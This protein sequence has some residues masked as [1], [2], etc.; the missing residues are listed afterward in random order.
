MYLV[1]GLQYV[2]GTWVAICIHLV[3]YLGCNMYLVL[4]LQC[5]WYLGCNMYL[6]L[7]LQ[8]VYTWWAVLRLQSVPG[9]IRD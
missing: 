5:T 3:L 7:G 2:P 9:A 8:Y 4:G 6:V 1:L